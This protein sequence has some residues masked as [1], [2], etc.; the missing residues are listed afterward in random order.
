MVKARQL[1]LLPA[2]TACAAGCYSYV[3][4]ANSPAPGHAVKASVNDEGAGLLTA[5]LGPGV[6]ELEGLLLNADTQQ[7]SIL[8]QSYVTRRQGVLNASGEAVRLEPRHI[9]VMKEKRLERTRSVLL[10]AALGASA[11]LA[12]EVFGPDGI[13][14][15]DENT[16]DPGPPTFRGGVNLGLRIP[17]RALFHP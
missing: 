13:L 3:P 6:L 1:L 17:F 16:E 12:I 8:V 14:F 2:L 11:I 10:A 9:V 4:V 15:E 7:V 5:Q